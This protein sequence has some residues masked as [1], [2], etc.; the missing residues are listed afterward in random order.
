MASVACSVLAMATPTLSSSE[1]WT[2]GVDGW[3]V[4]NSPAPSDVGFTV[5]HDLGGG[6]LTL[7]LPAGLFPG[8]G[9]ATTDGTGNSANFI[10]DYTGLG[11]GSGVALTF[12]FITFGDAP[13][14]LA[15]YF[16]SGVR[17]YTYDL[18]AAQGAPSLTGSRFYSVPIMAYSGWNLWGGGGTEAQYLLDLKTVSAIGFGVQATG[19]G[20]EVYGIDNLGFAV[21]EPESVWMILAV[22]LSLMITFRSRLS[23]LLGQIRVRIQRP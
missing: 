2:A 14:E 10:N 5:T 20:I 18:I 7:T 19:N 15:F 11:I 16:Q 23:G 3:T 8:Q 9:R 1:N 6:F 12:E 13:T 21:P 4:G 22:I 17:T